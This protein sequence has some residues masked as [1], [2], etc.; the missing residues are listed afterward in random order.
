M[1]RGQLCQW[2]DH[3][4]HRRH[5]D[6]LILQ[7]TLDAVGPAEGNCMFM[8]EPNAMLRFCNAGVHHIQQSLSQ[9]AQGMLVLEHL[10]RPD[11]YRMP[12]IV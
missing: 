5:G 11:G 12:L 6:G 8:S 9:A 10:H 2:G 1:C 4:C 3:E 7:A